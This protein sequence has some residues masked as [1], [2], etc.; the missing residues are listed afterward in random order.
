MAL[1]HDLNALHV[2]SNDVTMTS[3]QRLPP[4]TIVAINNGGGAIFNFLPVAA[5]GAAVRV[6]VMCARACV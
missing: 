2:L 3:A 6:Y 5:H 1:L 4:V